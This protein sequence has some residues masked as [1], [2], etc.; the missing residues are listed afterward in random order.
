VQFRGDTN[1]AQF[2]DQIKLVSVKTEFSFVTERR[3]TWLIIIYRVAK[4]TGTFQFH[5]SYRAV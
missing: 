2:Y 3:R 1:D 5:P 4:L